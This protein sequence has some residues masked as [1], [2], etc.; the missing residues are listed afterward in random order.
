MAITKTSENKTL[1]LCSIGGAFEYYDFS[2][3]ALMTPVISK[4]FFDDSV[5]SVALL[6]TFGIFAAGYFARFLGGFY[7]S[8][9]GDTSGRKKPFMIT[10]F[11]MAIPTLGIALLPTYQQIGFLAPLILLLLRI[12]QG[13]ALG[14]EAPCAMAYIHEYAN[15]KRKSLAMG[16]LFGGIIFGSFFASLLYSSLSSLMSPETF[17]SWGWRIPFAVGGI[18]GII[19]IYL[20]KSLNESKDFLQCKKSNGVLKVP[21]FT[22]FQKHFKDV[23]LGIIILLPSSTAFL[24]FLLISSK[25]LET[26]FLFEKIFIEKIVTLGFFL[27]ALFCIIFG[28]LSDKIKSKNVYIIGIISLFILTLLS[29]AAFQ[30]GSKETLTIFIILMSIT[31][32]ACV[33]SVFN[34]LATMFATKMRTSALALCLN[35]TNGLFIGITPYVFTQI[36]TIHYFN[37]FPMLYISFL[38]L[39]SLFLIRKIKKK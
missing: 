8:H 26:A 29:N 38:C 4:H 24:Y 6:K 15:E 18:L 28:Y 21:F 27:N 34:I 17:Y 11:L 5:P 13:F 31:L 1:F 19:G 23:V 3:F 7:F 2:L 16:F 36:A 22:L 37:H 14:G 9:L 30:S 32:G 12:A 20:R 39:I 35:T 25:T 33:G 10:L